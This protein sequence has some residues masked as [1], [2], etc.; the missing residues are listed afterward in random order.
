[1][2]RIPVA[3]IHNWR[4]LDVESAPEDFL[5]ELLIK[6]EGQSLLAHPPLGR[7]TGTAVWEREDGSSFQ[8]E[9]LVY[10]RH[11]IPELTERFREQ[12]RQSPGTTLEAFCSERKA[13]AHDIYEVRACLEREGDGKLTPPLSKP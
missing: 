1:M 8:D 11:F 7:H 2:Q 5:V 12:R 9:D 3:E 13:T 6:E 10:W 4:R